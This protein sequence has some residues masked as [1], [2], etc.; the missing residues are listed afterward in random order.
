MLLDYKLGQTSVILRVKLRNSTSGSG[1]GLTG[2]TNASSGLVIAAI[3]DNEATTT[4]YTQAGSTIDTI[5]TLGTYAAPTATHCRLKEVDATN[6]PG[7]YEIQFENSRLAVSSA[8]SLLVSISGA[9]N[10]A[11]CDFLVPL[12]QVDPYSATSFITGVNSLAPPAGWNTQTTAAIVTATWQDLT[13][14]TDF[15]TAG[16]IGLLVK[17]NLDT[18]VAS[19]STYAGGPVAQVTN[20]VTVG[21]NLDKT[22]YSLGP[23]GLDPVVIESGLNARQSLSIIAAACAGVGGTTS[24]LYKGAGVATTRIAFTASGGERTSVTLTVP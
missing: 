5:A 8:K 18:N 21:T 23:S 24:N 2:L 22:G 4:A 19:R 11:Q 12:R 1:A 7:V 13:S 16:S 17:T 10:L 3:A 9:T 6:H 14:T 15:A 20:P